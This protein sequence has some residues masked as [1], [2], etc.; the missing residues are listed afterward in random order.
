MSIVT[1]TADDVKRVLAAGVSC[2]LTAIDAAE[3]Y[4]NEAE[5]GDALVQIG[6]S[7]DSY[8]LSTKIWNTDHGHDRAL[9]AFEESVARLRTQPDM[10][11]IHWPCPMKGLY[12]ETWRALQELYEKGR[13]KAIGVSNFTIQH[14]E[15]LKAMGGVQPMVN[16][17]EMHPFFIDEAMLAYGKENGIQIEAWSPLLRGTKVITDPLIVEMAQAYGVSPAQLTIR[18]LTQYGVRV[19][20]KSNDPMHLK[21]N[22][23]V[24]GFSI[25]PQD[26]SRL[27]TLNTGKRAFQDPD[28]Y[29]I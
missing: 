9:M 10:L 19:I 27:R 13:V 11:L 14:L 15:A 18:Y 16:Q 17:I 22:S 23:D 24:F 7:R 8:F 25:T 12:Q 1:Y 26:I 5:V 4:H 2:G 3:H 28:E 21:E 6:R 29:E 20:V